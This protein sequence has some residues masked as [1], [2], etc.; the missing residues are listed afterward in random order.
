MLDFIASVGNAFTEVSGIFFALTTII[1][2]VM[3]KIKDRMI[4][5]LEE[6]LKVGDDLVESLEKLLTKKEEIIS[7]LT[8]KDANNESYIT[9]LNEH[10]RELERRIENTGITLKTPSTE[11]KESNKESV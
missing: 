4:N 2:L 8:M 10:L 1:A 5:N 7:L 3:N 11:E 9:A 6:T